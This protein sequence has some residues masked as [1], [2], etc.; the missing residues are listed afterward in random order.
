MVKCHF[1]GVVGGTRRI[2]R[3]RLI[4]WR[5]RL[6]GSR[7]IIAGLTLVGDVGNI[8]RFGIIHRVGDSLDAAIGE[9]D[10][11]TTIGRVLLAGLIGIKVNSSIVVLDSILVLQWKLPLGAR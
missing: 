3:S 8:A 1:L 4:C 6:V 9:K 7:L 11:V 10:P 5:G 2:N